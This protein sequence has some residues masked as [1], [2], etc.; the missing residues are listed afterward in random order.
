MTLDVIDL[1]PGMG[2]I[3]VNSDDPC[4][5]CS[6]G[7]PTIQADNM[8]VVGGACL[9]SNTSYGGN[10]NRGADVAPDPLAGLPEPWNPSAPGTDLGHRLVQNGESVTL[11]PGYYS[12]GIEMTGF[13]SRWHSAMKADFA[14]MTGDTVVRANELSRRGEE[15][16][17][18]SAR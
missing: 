3:Q 17:V 6:N 9:S 18:E 7:G 14:F 16:F 10:L 15:Q 1:I 2:G 11:M 12:G 5:V 13:A 4:A 8:N